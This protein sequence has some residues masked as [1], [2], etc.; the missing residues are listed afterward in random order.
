MKHRLIWDTLKK[1]I[2][3]DEIIV[4]TG[5]RQV[6]KT[7]TINW[8]LEN[9]PSTNKIYF[10]MQNIAER[11]VFETKNANS[12]I[13]E[14][15]RRGINTSQ[16]IYIA[17][18]EIQ[19]LDTLPGIIKYL[20]DHYKIKF[21]LTG[22]SS[23]YIKNRFSESMA[24]RKLIYEMYPLRF[25]EFLDFKG[26]NYK[27]PDLLGD[28]VQFD[29]NAYNLLSTLYEEYIEYG[30]LPKVVLVN[31]FEKKRQLLEEIFSSYITLDV[32]TLAD[33][34]SSADFRKVIKLIATRIGNRTNI[35][36]LC[37]IIGISRPT[38]MAY[39]DFLE[40]TYLI[41]TVEAISNSED[42]R[43]RKPPKI[44]FV[45]TGIANLNADLSG[46]CKFENTVGHQLSFYGVLNY[47]ESR[48]GEIDF[49]INRQLAVEVKE[50][51]TD[52][53]LTKLHTRS[54]SLGIRNSLIVGREKS[55]KFEKY[56]W[57]G[58]IK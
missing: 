53:H 2:D 19:L 43:V 45:D 34:R 29:N 31:D 49:I 4:I 16:R 22:S 41:R 10:D 26:I 24:G 7:T 32:E 12:I 36:E 21:F 20:Y 40:K 52:S 5:P 57:G 44:Y 23:Y 14:L 46:G 3:S 30:G 25:Q 55:A 37:K 6:G 13:N 47:F 48:D 1:E 39:I 8:L 50:T 51:P 17:I 33:F 54:G 15:Q 18:D 56:L 28:T 35:A 27:L 9:I 58:C 11:E 38:V 42:V